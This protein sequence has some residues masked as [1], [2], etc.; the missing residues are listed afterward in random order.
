[1]TFLFVDTSVFL[2]YRRLDEIDW[3]AI[4]GSSEVTLVIAPVV[5]RELDD[6]K[7]NHQIQRIRNRARDALPFL[8]RMV[9]ES[10]AKSLRVHLLSTEPTLDFR[11]HNLRQEIND[12]WH[13]ASILDWKQRHATDRVVLATADY[14]LEMKAE[15]YGVE[16]VSLPE[17]AKL[18]EPVDAAEKRISQLERENAN[19]KLRLPQLR[20]AF[21]ANKEVLA[22]ALPAQMENPVNVQAEMEKI[23]VKYK[24]LDENPALRRTKNISATGLDVLRG[25]VSRLDYNKERNAELRAFYNQYEKYLCALDAYREQMTR[26]IKWNIYLHNDGG[27]PA[28]DIDVHMHLP[29]GFKLW[30]ASKAPREPT[31]PQPPARL[32]LQRAI[33]D[34]SRAAILPKA[35]RDPGP[36]PNVSAPTITRTSSYDV[37][38]HI[39]KLKHGYSCPLA[40]YVSIFESEPTIRPFQI[41]YVI[42]AA[43]LPVA[44]TGQLTIVIKREEAIG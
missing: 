23:H 39:R 16:L 15:A 32:E 40:S 4:L 41:D 44:A 25:I 21:A 31:P 36:P 22:V 28:E 1:M 37:Q 6:H 27:I 13:I 10:G 30:D 24:L 14:A 3:P 42:T 11:R 20:L 7:F 38:Q 35:L 9:K 18:P 33:P 2:H 43:N 29:D 19:L 17:G 12:D 34:L 5:L 26:R 8:R